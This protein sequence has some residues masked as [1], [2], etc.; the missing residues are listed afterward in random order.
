MIVFPLQKLLGSQTLQHR[1]KKRIKSNLF[2]LL[3]HEIKVCLHFYA[4]K[5]VNIHHLYAAVKCHIHQP[6]VFFFNQDSLDK[7]DR[8][9]FSK[10][11]D[12][13][14]VRGAALGKTRLLCPSI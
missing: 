10:T 5:N 4:H 12:I 13:A 11:A 1:I 3:S 6:S 9:Y 14:S 2:V 8:Y 7:L